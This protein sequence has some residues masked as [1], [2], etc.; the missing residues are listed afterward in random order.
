MEPFIHKALPKTKGCREGGLRVCGPLGKAGD[1]RRFYPQTDYRPACPEGCGA[2]CG[3][4]IH[5]PWTVG[6]RE[7]A[8]NVGFALRQALEAARACG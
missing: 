7:P 1:E 2:L 4:V 6:W 3:P 8:K 5:M